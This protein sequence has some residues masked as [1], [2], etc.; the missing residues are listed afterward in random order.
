MK[1]FYY[2]L[3]ILM[4]INLTIEKANAL[5]E[6]KYYKCPSNYMYTPTITLDSFCEDKESFY[7]AMNKKFGTNH[8]CKGLYREEFEK[9]EREYNSGQCEETNNYYINGEYNTATC[10][11]SFT[12]EPIPK[13]IGHSNFSKNKEDGLQCT[14]NL[15]I[16][17]NEEYPNIK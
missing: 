15:Y 14:E 12:T 11:V 10:T 7:Q 16:K 1:K 6:N 8:T 17:L 3:L 9:A 4:T 2:L 5:E 13:I